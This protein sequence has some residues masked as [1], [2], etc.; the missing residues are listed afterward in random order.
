MSDLEEQKE[1]MERE[2]SELQS[3]MSHMQ[4][5]TPRVS[6]E[7]VELRVKEMQQKVDMEAATRKRLEVS[8]EWVESWRMKEGGVG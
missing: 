5:E 8:T 1:K 2:I 6:D 3:R 4:V 7:V